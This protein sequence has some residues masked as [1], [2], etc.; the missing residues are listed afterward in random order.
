M[1]AAGTDFIIL[2]GF[3]GSGK[4]TLLRDYLALPEAADTAVI[5]NEAGEIGLDG[6]I[7]AEG[8]TLPIALLSNGC[9]CCSLGSG[10][11]STVLGML[12]ERER[13]RL[14]PPARIVL[15]TSGLAKP[16]PILRSLVGLA[17]LRLRVGVVATFD[18]TRGTGLEAFE[19]AAAQWV[20]AQALVLTKRDAVSAAALWQAREAAAGVNPT[21][22]LL[23]CDDRRTMLRATFSLR[24][25][26]AEGGT[27]L[28][29]ESVG[30]HHPRISLVLVRFHQAVPWDDL[31]EWL[32]NLA[33]LC[34]ERLLRAKG[35][36]RITGAAQ[37]LLVQSVGTVFSAPRP[38]GADEQGHS[39]LVLIL[40][41]FDPRK[42]S[43]ISPALPMN[44][45]GR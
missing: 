39:F 1:I 42:L 28:Q 3:L 45:T 2:T 33:G 23:D 10:L 44:W 37:P 41:D 22:D 35:L 7:L 38:F 11:E 30:L 40:R 17:P 14:P 27:L 25:Q 32:D 31:A 16:G 29:A 26:A 34:G 19:E 21:A 12:A 20:G 24:A 43:E 36:V 15:E 5:V 4:T 18:C 9:V 13:Q 8:G 6:A